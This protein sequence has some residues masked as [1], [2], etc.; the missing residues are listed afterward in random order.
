MERVYRCNMDST[1][2]PFFFAESVRSLRLEG[3]LRLESKGLA[4]IRIETLDSR[5]LFKGL[6]ISHA[7]SSSRNEENCADSCASS[8]EMLRYL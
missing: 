7:V 6:Q 4:E 8:P 5:V 1:N 2:A 3:I